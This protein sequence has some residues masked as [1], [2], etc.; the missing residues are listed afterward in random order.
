MLRSIWLI[1]SSISRTC[2]A[3]P[4]GLDQRGDRVVDLLLH[5]PAHGQEVAA[6][7]LQLGVELREM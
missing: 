1:W 2:W 4:V 5:Q 7:F 6:H 3:R